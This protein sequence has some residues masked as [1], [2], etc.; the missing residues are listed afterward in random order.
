MR[1]TTERR[2]AARSTGP[3]SDHA[4]R[5]QADARPAA[6]AARPA[7][8]LL[9]RLDRRLL[10]A[11]EDRVHLSVARDVNGF[12]V[13]TLSN[14]ADRAIYV[15]NAGS[16]A[17]PGTSPTAPLKT[18]AYARTLVRNGTGDQLLLRRG[19]RFNETLTSWTQSGRS[20]VEPVV[21]GAYTD[22]ARPSVERPVVASSTG[23]TFSNNTASS[24][25]TPLSNV[26]IMGVSFTAADRN[27]RQPTS[28]FTIADKPESQGGTIGVNLLGAV[29]NVLVE[30]SSFQYFRHGLTVQSITGWGAPSKITVR[31]NV[32]ADN[33]ARSYDSAGNFVT[34]EGIYAQ[35]TAGLTLEENVFDHNGWTDPAYGDFGTYATIYNHN[36]YLNIG[37]TN[38]VV[39]GNVFANAASHGI[40]MRA[41]GIATNNLFINNPIAMSF[42]YVNGSEKAGGV[43]GEISGNVVYGSN[44]INGAPRGWGIEI[45]NTKP[46]GG[47]VIKNNIYTSYAAG[48]QPAIKL[49]YG[50]NNNNPA[51]G[52]G[53]NDLTISNNVVYGWTK[54]VY[55]NPG[56]VP[57]GTGRQALNGVSVLNNEFQQVNEL[58]VVIHGP[59]VSPTAE[60]WRGNR[61]DTIGTASSTLKYWTV[62]GVGK[63][64]AE[65]QALAEPSAAAPEI[66]YPNPNVSPQAYNT[67]IGGTGTL[68]AFLGE[69]RKQSATFWRPQYRSAAAINYIR[70]GFSG[71]RVDALPPAAALA[72]A[73]T[74]TA[75]G[76]ATQ[77]LT[78]TWSDDNQVNLASIGNGDLL[79]TGPNGYAQVATLVSATPNA[80]GSVVTAVYTVPAALGAWSAAGNGTYAVSVQ[81]GEVYDKSNNFAPGGSLGS[82]TVQIAA[83]APTASLATVATVANPTAPATLTV[84]YTVASGGIDVSTLGADD[85]TVSGPDGGTVTA[86]LSAVTPAGTGTP[87][88]ATYLVGPP[89]GGWTEAQ[90]GTYVVVLNAGS[91]ANT[92]G[93]TVGSAVLGSF[94]VNVSVPTATAS[95]PTITVGGTAPQTITVRYQD[96]NGI[97]AATVDSA[98]LTVEGPNGFASGVT[99]LTKAGAGTAASP[100]VATYRLNAPTGGW[101]ADANGTY[102]VVLGTDQVRN[103]GGVAA[104]GG[105]IGTF[106]VDLD[107]GGPVAV[108]TAVQGDVFKPVPG[109]AVRTITVAFADQTGVDKT[110]IGTGDVYLNMPDGS[111]VVPTLVSV[112]GSGRSVTATYSITIPAGITAATNGY[113]GIG[114]Y[115]G[116]VLDTLGQ[117]TDGGSIGSFQIS[118][119]SDPPI[120]YGYS[121]GYVDAQTGVDVGVTYYDFPGVDEST[122]G[123]G[124]LVAIGPDGVVRPADLV[125]FDPTSGNF[126]QAY[127]RVPAP[128]GGWQ[129]ENNGT[130][131]VFVQAGAVTDLSGN[132]IPRTAVADFQISV[133]TAPTVAMT[134]DAIAPGEPVDAVTIRFNQTVGGFGLEDLQ[135]TTAGSNANLLDGLPNVGLQ[136]SDGITYQLTGLSQV[137]AAGGMYTLTLT[138][139]GSDVY[140]EYGLPLAKDASVQFGTDLTPPG[141]SMFTQPVATAGTGPATFTVT[142]TDATAVNANTLG[143]GDFLVQNTANGYKQVAKL[144]SLDS[145]ASGPTR[146]ATYSVPAPA[147]GWS[148]AWNGTYAILTRPGEV[149][150]TLGNKVPDWKFLG[151]LTVNITGTG[152][153]VDTT[154]PTAT[155]AAVAT[156]R[157]TAVDS[158]AVTF[159]EKVYNLD[160]SD[161]TLSRNGGANLLTSAQTLTT[162]DGITYTLGG[163][164]GLTAADGAYTLTVGSAGTPPVADAS[165][166]ALA[167]TATRSWTVSTVVTTPTPT[168][169]VISPSTVTGSASA[170]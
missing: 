126:T 29:S 60:T 80:D 149:A 28:G 129:A 67:S 19:D 139:A 72:A 128:T 99:L 63:T 7:T 134:A 59:A 159:S 123:A 114:L 48:G 122:I 45:G 81:G 163:L 93:V 56:F 91:V 142:F 160:L 25:R 104:G 46:G 8:T 94:Q 38:V 14:P 167:G 12:T 88:T 109:P 137:T 68:D 34:S 2:A 26:Y 111:D 107:V 118:I 112:T 117:P 1:F 92:Q 150:D 18:L 78:V 162:T 44:S 32:I 106:D 57:G 95:A 9:A 103:A 116:S 144:V 156:P 71:Q 20:A 65:W 39:T 87:R 121:G 37:N 6:A 24:T 55:I 135:L 31:R 5:P 10:E 132:P 115:A 17:N 64:L 69:A 148:A 52:V 3:S 27:Y 66:T 85:L 154:P 62:K 13:V 43:T 11:L 76:G 151:S 98:D 23:T 158:V 90:N 155:I 105:T 22:P 133:P 145:F 15:S 110:T 100:L 140:G 51:D 130:Y 165:G 125:G 47:T 70:A 79:V 141:M 30:D 152:G 120:A 166:N 40:Q 108:A 146:I 50:T 157:A 96:A 16:D 161:L 86:T 143:D 153:Q 53:V 73:P 77:T 54:G 83:A 36:A 61:Y 58:P 97:N 136:T 164:T 102:F 89:A 169:T 74:I 170:Q 82:F 131:Q 42:G 168:I 138:A 4:A 124:D 35:D 21:I 41:G 119:D 113:V 147:G 84:T 49:D 75:G 33:Y 101:V 127:Y